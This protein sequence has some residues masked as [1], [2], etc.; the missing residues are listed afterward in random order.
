MILSQQ[1]R[2]QTTLSQS[3]P[4]KKRTLILRDVLIKKQKKKRF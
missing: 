3:L 4:S 2:M 1:C